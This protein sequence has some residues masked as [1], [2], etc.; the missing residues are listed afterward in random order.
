MTPLSLVVLFVPEWFLREERGYL[1]SNPVRHES[2]LKYHELIT[3]YDTCILNLWHYYGMW[4]AVG[5]RF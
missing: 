5:D 3:S 2:D 1:N 4:V